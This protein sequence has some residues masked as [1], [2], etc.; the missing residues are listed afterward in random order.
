MKRRSFFGAITGMF[1]APAAI[2]AGKTLADFDAPSV[3]YSLVDYDTLHGIGK[4]RHC[5]GREFHDYLNCR[6][7]G[8]GD[9]DA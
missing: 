6:H 2:A 8:A 9:W 1:A 3:R 5:G 7:C 4:C